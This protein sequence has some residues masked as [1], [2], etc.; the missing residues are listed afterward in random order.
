M[1]EV[2]AVIGFCVLVFL[3]VSRMQ[4]EER[5]ERRLGTDSEL[6]KVTSVERRTKTVATRQ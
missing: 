2:Y 4:R 6:Q 1:N 3:L 5:K